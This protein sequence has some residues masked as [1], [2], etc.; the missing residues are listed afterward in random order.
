MSVTIRNIKTFVTAPGKTDLVV[1][2][3][4]TSEP[5]LYGYGCAT[6]TQRA[7]TVKQAV[8]EIRP[9]VIGRPV[10]NIEDCWQ[11]LYG[12][13]YW[14]NGP[15]LNNAISGI[16]EALWDIKGK[17]ANMAV[18][19]LLGGRCRNAAKTFADAMGKTKEEV[20]DS[21]AKRLAEGYDHIRLFL[22][23]PGDPS[24]VKDSEKPENAPEG[25]Y[26]SPGIYIREMVELFRYLRDRFGEAP[27]YMIDIHER[28][29][30]AETITLAKALE[31]YRLFFLEDSLPPEQIEWFSA[32]R[33]AVSTPLAMGELFNNVN[34]FKSLI[35]NRQIDYIRCHISQLGG[36]TPAKKLAA[37]SEYFGVKTAWHGPGDISPIGM[38]AQIHLDLATPN[39]GFQEFR[40]YDNIMYDMFPGAP[41]LRKTYLYV[42]DKPG[43]GVEFNE[44]LASKYPPRGYDSSGF[45]CRLPD[46]TAVR[47]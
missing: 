1:V 43:F 21:V 30:P 11:Q 39:F 6:F 22:G 23:Y 20:G 4:E 26:I 32:L 36:L 17:M 13:S 45:L 9:L 10:E 31:P 35:V 33:Q 34:E 19:D 46:G 14:R 16:D 12:S 29:S 8:E 24:K 44:E 25:R 18:Y 28:L 38:A 37:F 7:L 47:S 15:V 42:N 27:E 5:G 41:E 3:V 40:P 2:K